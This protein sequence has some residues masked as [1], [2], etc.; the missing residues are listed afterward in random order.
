MH[1][2]PLSW[3]LPLSCRWTPAVRSPHR[4][5][6]LWSVDKWQHYS[7]IHLWG[8]LRKCK[9]PQMSIS[10]ILK[11]KNLPGSAIVHKVHHLSLQLHGSL[12]EPFSCVNAPTA[13]LTNF[14]RYHILSLLY[15][16]C[17]LLWWTSCGR[18][19][20]RSVQ[21]ST[22]LLSIRQCDVKSCRRPLLEGLNVVVILLTTNHS[23]FHFPSLSLKLKVEDVE[24]VQWTHKHSLLACAVLLTAEVDTF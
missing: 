15:L 11:E 6:S 12:K 20:K 24:P 8:F 4:Y 18:G 21:R 10:V 13:N 1:L 19:R 23:T 16:I 7:L 9:Y 17:R 3:S 2:K 14:A 5:S 22:A